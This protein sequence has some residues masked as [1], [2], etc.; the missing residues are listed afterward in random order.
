MSTVELRT[1]ARI[2]TLDISNKRVP[3]DRIEILLSVSRD[4]IDDVREFGLGEVE[5]TI[6]KSDVVRTVVGSRGGEQ[7]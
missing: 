3:A 5:I 1:Q 7:A 6:T 2:H 4:L